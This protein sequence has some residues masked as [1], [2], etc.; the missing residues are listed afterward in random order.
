MA[1][2]LLDPQ[3]LPTTHLELTVTLGQEMVKLEKKVN[4]LIETA[5]QH[6]RAISELKEKAAANSEPTAATYSTFVSH[7]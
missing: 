3:P 1:I 6:D 7:T 2:A 5:A 4:V